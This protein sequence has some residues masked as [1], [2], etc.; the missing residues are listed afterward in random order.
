M[1]GDWTFVV[2]GLVL[3][4]MLP[5]LLWR[6]ASRGTQRT[7]MGTF[8]AYAVTPD[9]TLHTSGAAGSS[10]VSPGYIARVGATPDCWLI[11]LASGMLLIVPRELIPDADA[12]LLVR[13]LP[14]RLQ[15][16]AALHPAV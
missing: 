1:G 16:P 14:G 10:T 9:G 8:V 3:L 13:H 11:A 6:A 12:S 2:V 5:L 15:P 4:A 7:P